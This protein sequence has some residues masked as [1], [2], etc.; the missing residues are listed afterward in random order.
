[1]LND[2][3]IWIFFQGTFSFWE[4]F[5]CGSQ[6]H[7]SLAQIRRNGNEVYNLSLLDDTMMWTCRLLLEVLNF[8]SCLWFIFIEPDNWTMPGIYGIGPLQFYPG[9]TSSG[10]SILTWRK[11]WDTLQ[12]KHNWR[13]V[14]Y[15]CLFDFLY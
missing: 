14:L 6:K 8:L 1:M 11:C 2:V 3:F 4:R 5:G 7:N 9:L 15:L 10:T 13:K 12:V